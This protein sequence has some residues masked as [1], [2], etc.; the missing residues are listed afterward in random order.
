MEQDSESTNPNELKQQHKERTEWMK[1]ELAALGIKG[2][3]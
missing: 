1:S 2:Q 3:K